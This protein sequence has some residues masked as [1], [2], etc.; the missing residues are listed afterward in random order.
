VSGLDIGAVRVGLAAALETCTD[1]KRTF[2]YVVDR[3]PEY[4]AAYVGA[5]EPIVY[6]GRFV[7]GASEVQFPLVFV[8][9]RIDAEASQEVLDRLMSQE[10]VQGEYISVKDALEADRTLGG[11]CDTLVVERADYLRAVQI[12]GTDYLAMDVT[13]K[14]FS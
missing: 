2:A 1:V 9:G 11:A 12:A 8:T 3:I 4:P 7:R 14:V 5:P 6:G 13:V 10:T